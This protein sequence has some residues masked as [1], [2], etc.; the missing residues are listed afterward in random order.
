MPHPVVPEGCRVRD[1]HVSLDVG[2]GM[3]V[4]VGIGGAKIGETI[5]STFGREREDRSVCERQ[6]ER[7]V[8]FDAGLVQVEIR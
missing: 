8:E 2:N 6:G 5:G 3:S 7:V 1:G 4:D